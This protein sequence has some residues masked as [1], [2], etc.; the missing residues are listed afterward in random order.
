MIDMV[1]GHGGQIQVGIR[2]LL[3][4]SNFN[5]FLAHILLWL[6][7]LFLRAGCLAL[8]FTS[9]L[10]FFQMW[11]LWNAKMEIA[12]IK[13]TDDTTD[14]EP[15]F[16]FVTIPKE[17]VPSQELRTRLVWVVYC[18]CTDDIL[19]FYCRI[20]TSL[21]SLNDSSY[22]FA[23]WV[24]FGKIR[25]IWYLVLGGVGFWVLMLSFMFFL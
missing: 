1:S 25:L 22:W 6:T 9:T 18:S 8:D 14:D 23:F 16:S 19:E 12:S 3:M 24:Y 10:Y 15:P 17:Q 13:L 2:I 21:I 4:T 7:T 20:G 5:I 11:Y